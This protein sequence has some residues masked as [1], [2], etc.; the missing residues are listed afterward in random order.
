MT[1]VYFNLAS[2]N[3]F[4]DWTNAGMITANDDWSGVASIMGYRGDGLAGGSG[5]D[6]RGITGHDASRVLDV[7]H[8]QTAPNSFGTGGVTEFAITDP[9]IA[10]SG[11][12]TARAPYIVLH[13]DATG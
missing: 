6:P 9:T 7:N 10:I 4:Q 3:F 5:A 11:S 1:A 13:L 8:G 12:G 2:G